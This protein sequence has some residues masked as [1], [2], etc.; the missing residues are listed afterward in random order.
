[1]TLSSNPNVTGTTANNEGRLYLIIFWPLSLVFVFEDCFFSAK[2]FLAFCGVTF[3]RNSFQWIPNQPFKTKNVLFLWCLPF[4]LV[5]WSTIVVSRALLHY[6]FSFSNSLSKQLR[7]LM[8]VNK[9]SLTKIITSFPS[10][11]QFFN[12]VVKWVYRVLTKLTIKN[13]IYLLLTKLSI[14]NLLFSKFE[15]SLSFD[16]SYWKCYVNYFCK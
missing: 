3:L 13:L 4:P 8:K 10:F 15:L 12:W 5:F 2:V 11:H 16:N 6:N 7:N 9:S 14:E 1:M